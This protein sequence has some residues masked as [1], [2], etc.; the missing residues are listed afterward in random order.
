MIEPEMAFA[1]LDD[2]AELAEDFI[3]FLCAHVLDND[4]RDL[5][6]FDERIE[7]GL[8]QT[9]AKTAEAGFKHIS[10]TEAVEILAKSGEKFEYAPEWS[11]GLQT[12]H[13]NI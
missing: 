3:K 7:K 6:F 13:E 4:K 10:Y 11:A 9:L 12:E 1:D 8:L 2:D 5:E